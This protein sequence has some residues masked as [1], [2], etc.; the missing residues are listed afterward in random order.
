MDIFLEPFFIRSLLGGLLIA[1]MAP[2]LGSFVVLRRQSMIGDTLAHITIAG[3]AL[4]LLINVYPLVLGIV[5]AVLAS[6][7]IERIRKIYKT[8]AELSIAIM[9]SGGVALATLL[10]TLGKGFN[11]NVMSYLFGSIYTLDKLDLTLVL[12]V[13]AVVCFVIFTYYKELMLITFDE[14]AA[15]VNGLPVRRFNRLLAVLVALVV[16]VAIKIVGA[17]LVSALL[18]IPV[19]TSLL[20]A[21]GFRQSMLLAVIFS[22]VA[23]IGGLAVAGIWNMAPGGTVVLLAIAMLVVVMF[24]RRGLRI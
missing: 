6:F 11:I 15:T 20:I 12:L 14:D 22:Q 16:S 13:T 1:L 24:L 23:M 5:F 3:V 17:L 4:G 9:L 7:A 2:L 21:R 19:A 10:F 8:Y 18:I